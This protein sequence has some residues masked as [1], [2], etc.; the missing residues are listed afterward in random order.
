M[1]DNLNLNLDQNL[2][3]NLGAGGARGS[4]LG[5]RYNT[6]DFSR[7]S[8]APVPA[9]ANLPSLYS[10]DWDPEH[11]A[12]EYVYEFMTA[13][14][15]A[16]NL[17]PIWAIWLELYYQTHVRVPRTR[18]GAFWFH[19]ARHLDQAALANQLLGMVSA[20]NERADRA[21]EIVDQASAA[22]ALAYWTGM[23]H[24][25]PAKEPRTYLLM[26]VAR[27]IGEYVAMGL[28]DIYRMRRAAQLYPWIMPLIDGPDTPSYPSSHALQAY[29]ISDALK[30][31]LGNHGQI[32]DPP[33]VSPNLPGPFPAPPA[34]P[35]GAPPAWPPPPSVYQTAIA[36]DHLAARVAF[37]REVAGVHYRMDSAAGR[38]VARYCVVQL[39]NLPANSM[40]RQLVAAAT[41][42]LVNLP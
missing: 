14:P 2:N 4:G 25:D 23:L 26:R 38:Y 24:V 8:P 1:P 20:S 16:Y 40:F 3:L 13:V 28:K 32:W 39:Y 6:E 27:K 34:W 10:A 22:G 31:C 17:S 33:P 5:P 29:L 42:E 36:L 30:L 18:L 35:L 11:R 41:N 9:P 15:W 7:L 37:N 19:A 21:S 12:W